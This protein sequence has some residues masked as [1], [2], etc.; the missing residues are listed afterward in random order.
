MNIARVY[1][2]LNEHL[3]RS[4]ECVVVLEPVEEEKSYIALPIRLDNNPVALTEATVRATGVITA[5]NLNQYKNKFYS[6]RL[7]EDDS[8]NWFKQLIGYRGGST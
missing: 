5:H 3:I 6:I 4:I 2:S 1:R 8:G 7:E